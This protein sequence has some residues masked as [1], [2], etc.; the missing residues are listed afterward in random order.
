MAAQCGHATIGSFNNA[1]RF[2][3]KSEYWHKVI[4][5]WTQFGSEKYQRKEPVKAASEEALL[6]IQNQCHDLGIPC[7]VV[8]DAGHT[9]IAAGSLTVCGIGPVT[10]A[11]VKALSGTFASL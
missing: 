9:Q 3:E 4:N 6:A 8:A 5:A 1:K 7:Y 10:E 2:A 11:Q